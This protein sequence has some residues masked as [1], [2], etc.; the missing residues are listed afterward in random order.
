MMKR[1]RLLGIVATAASADLTFRSPARPA[2]F[3]YKLGTP[4][5]LEYPP[6]I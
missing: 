5:P 2:Q 4:N 6:N 1:S 3:V